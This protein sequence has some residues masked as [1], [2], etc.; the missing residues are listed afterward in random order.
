MGAALGKPQMIRLTPAHIADG[1]RVN[2][3]YLLQDKTFCAFMGGSALSVFYLLAKQFSEL[4]KSK[5]GSLDLAGE[6][7]GKTGKKRKKR[8]KNM[9][10]AFWRRLKRILQIC[11]PS[12]SSKEAVLL[13]VQFSLLVLRTLITV[14][15]FRVNTRLLTQ[16]ISRASWKIWARWLVNMFAWTICGG[17]TNAALKYVEVLCALNFRKMLT[18]H[19]H[20]LYMRDN[21]FYK[22]NSGVPPRKVK[23]GEEK[24][25]EKVE[26]KTVNHVDQRIAEDVRLFCD[27]LAHLYGHSFKPILE[28]TMILSST[29]SELGIIRPISLYILLAFLRIGLRMV[30]PNIGKMVK[31]EQEAEGAFRHAHHRLRSHAEA[32]A[33]LRGGKTE[34]Y[35]LN[36]S[37]SNLYKLR[38]WH[39][40]LSLIKWLGDQIFKFQGIMIGGIFIHVPFLN[41][42]PGMSEAD[43]IS[44][45]RACEVVMLKAGG[46]FSEILLLSKHL[47]TLGG[48]VA[49][50]GELLE[51]LG[52]SPKLNLGKSSASIRAKSPACHQDTKEG[53]P[54]LYIE[55]KGVS[56]GAPEPSGKTRTLVKNL[57]LKVVEGSSVL[58][59]GP[60]G[61][62]KTSLF[63][64][65]AGLWEPIQG[66]IRR[67]DDLIMW[68]PQEPYMV[69]GTLRDQVT[70]PEFRGIS[71]NVDAN[72][73]GRVTAALKKAGLESLISRS[74]EGLDQLSAEWKNELSGGER[75]RLAFA[76]LFFHKPKFAVIDEATSAINVGGEVSLYQQLVSERCTVFSIAHRTAL[77]R[78]H[79]LELEFAGDGSGAY[80]FFKLQP[81]GEP[82]VIKR[83]Q[84]NIN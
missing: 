78:F 66:Q 24:T 14:R 26:S 12:A 21:G 73:D 18:S 4:R 53:T 62:G 67:P 60:N 72:V 52:D 59:T 49:R 6:R 71:S 82:N 63:R 50:I 16:A 54:P 20:R 25:G 56:V 37:F 33:F 55:F 23:E 34:E 17:L 44:N 27:E 7:K 11:I 47:Q 65:L 19:L 74:V 43:R 29:F 10:K 57:N 81:S 80:K 15:I 76:R 42:P 51:A 83:V 46:A 70:Y 45:F 28:F 39:A 30:S 9:D 40:L 77:R 38:S 1:L 84:L 68:L 48:Y 35:I 32:V 5:L 75:Q 41:S 61:C 58:V 64:V 31:K 22:L 8:G 36:Q 2:Y 3:R 69:T 13:Y 79:S